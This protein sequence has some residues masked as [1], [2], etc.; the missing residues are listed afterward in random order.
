MRA[1]FSAALRI[2][3]DIVL[4]HRILSVSHPDIVRATRLA[5]RYL[6]PAELGELHSRYPKWNVPHS[7]FHDK[8]HRLIAAWL[9][10]RWAAKEAAKKA[11]DAS[12]LSFRDLKV[13]VL[14]GG[15]VQIICD[16]GSAS[17]ASDSTSTDK[18]TQQV[19][20]LSISHDGPYS[21]ATVLAEPLHPDIK[22]ELGRRKSEA[23]SRVS[24][25]YKSEHESARV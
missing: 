13:E 24:L 14:P 4:A 18:I 16:I 23:E 15:G 10:G 6:L 3:T 11:W 12:L 9:A 2:G 25:S 21:I 17:S 22:A 8:R 20:Q 19:A 5:N 7:T 1:P